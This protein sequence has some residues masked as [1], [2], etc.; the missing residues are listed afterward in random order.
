M[1]RPI[2]GRHN[3]KEKEMNEYRFSK[4]LTSELVGKSEKADGAFGRRHHSRGLYGF[5]MPPKR[6]ELEEVIEE[7]RVMTKEQFIGFT[8]RKGGMK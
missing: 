5:Y 1:T 8:I 2:T 3:L 6:K 7:R 4:Y